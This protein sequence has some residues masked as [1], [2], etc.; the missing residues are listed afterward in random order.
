M[1][2][3]FLIFAYTAGAFTF[4]SPCSFPMLPSYISY[5]LRRENRSESLLALVLNGIKLGFITSLGFLVVLMVAG[6][7]MS[8][9]LV[10]IGKLIPYFVM[11][12]GAIFAALGILYLAGKNR[13]FSIFLRASHLI[14]KKY[15]EKLG[16]FLYGIAY[17]LAAMGCSL[18]MF[19][20]IVSGSA[21]FN[22]SSAILSLISYFLGM[23]TLM[24]PVS[25][26]TS[27]SG[28]LVSRKFMSVM[29]F[30]ERA[31]GLVLLVTG[32]YLIWF[33]ARVFFT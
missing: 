24:I 26:L 10:Q 1:D 18:P 29:H 3:A 25:V 28:G 22:L 15:G 27:L 32:V 2:F 30:V 17:A 21:A 4:L 9:A 6:F 11:A 5:F 12:I 7:L 13:S 31:T 8:L 20:L 14:H 33:E 23:A 19:L 16:P